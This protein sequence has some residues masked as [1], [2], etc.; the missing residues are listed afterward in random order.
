MECVIYLYLIKLSSSILEYHIEYSKE[1]KVDLTVISIFCNNQ[2]EKVE[3]EI[4][5]ISPS[6]LLKNF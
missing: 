4:L 5:E 6:V 2:I 1:E 3:V